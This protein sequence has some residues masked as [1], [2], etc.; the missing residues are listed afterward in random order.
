MPDSEV[1]T[2]YYRL[3]KRHWVYFIAD[4]GWVKIGSAALPYLRLRDLQTGN[5]RELRLVAIERGGRRREDEL[6]LQHSEVCVRGEWF[7][8][9]DALNN[10]M[11]RLGA[12]P[13]CCGVPNC[14]M[15]A[16][17]DSRCVDHL[18]SSQKPGRCRQNGCHTVPQRD[19][20]HC[21]RHQ[22]HT[23]TT[24]PL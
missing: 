18:K 4:G 24:T 20:Q 12:P 19:A 10:Y 5:P 14:Y 6:H 9:T 21:Y 8:R 17:V 3:A 11:K 23:V 13:G 16:L 7:C 15:M 2:P 22:V 1:D